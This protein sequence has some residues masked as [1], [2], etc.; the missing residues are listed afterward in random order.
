MNDA[1]EKSLGLESLQEELELLLKES[2]PTPPSSKA[3]NS[4]IDNSGVKQ[5]PEETTYDN[6]LL[7]ENIC[8][9]NEPL[10][11]E[12]IPVSKN[13]TIEKEHIDIITYNIK[14]HYIEQTIPLD[15]TVA[16]TEQTEE[17]PIPNDNHYIKDHYEPYVSKIENCLDD[18]NINFIETADKHTENDIHNIH[19]IDNIDKNIP[20]EN[21]KEDINLHE[22]IKDPDNEYVV[23]HVDSHFNQHNETI[24]TKIRNSI[25]Y[26]FIGILAAGAC[27]GYYIYEYQPQ[28]SLSLDPLSLSWSVWCLFHTNDAVWSDFQNYEGRI[29]PTSQVAAIA[30]R[31]KGIGP[32]PLAHGI[33]RRS[34]G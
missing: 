23:S 31:D 18:T 30:I 8:Q 4:T 25:K 33:P 27:L 3:P 10:I 22:Y 14:D 26:I 13:T 19:D 6:E 1:N 11:Q 24:L 20:N 34:T 32:K 17:I 16:A 15:N 5:K 2:L 9:S 28:I 7:F 12:D 29:L 21:I